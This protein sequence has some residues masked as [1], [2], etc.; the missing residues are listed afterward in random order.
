[1]MD[2]IITKTS[3]YK[4]KISIKPKRVI[5]EDE[6]SLTEDNIFPNSVKNILY[7]PYYRSHPQINPYK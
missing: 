7:M 6:E 1:M 2:C 3:P 4:V 5:Q